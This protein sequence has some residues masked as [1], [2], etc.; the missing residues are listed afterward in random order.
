MR[1]RALWLRAGLGAGL[2]SGLGAG[3]ALG[4]VGCAAEDGPGGGL[5]D[6]GADR[7]VAFDQ[8]VDRG[9]ADQGAVACALTDRFGP[10]T[11]ELPAADLS[12]GIALDLAVCAAE[13]DWFALE[14]PVGQAVRVQVTADRRVRAALVDPAGAVLAQAEGRAPAL[15]GVAPLRGLR[16]RVEGL[17]VGTGYDLQVTAFE[18]VSGC[19]VDPQEAEDREGG[20]A[21]DGTVTRGLC[22][23]DRD[24]VRVPGEPGD[25]VALRVV[26][27]EGAAVQAVWRQA[28]WRQAGARSAIATHRGE[29]TPGRIWTA[30]RRLSDASTTLDVTG[31]PARYRVEAEVVSAQGGSAERLV[32]SRV[33]TPDRVST[34]EGTRPAAERP[35]PGLPVLLFDLSGLVVDA[36]R[37]DG[38]GDATWRPW[39]TPEE[40][41]EGWPRTALASLPGPVAVEVGPAEG[42]DGATGPW[43]VPLVAV[44]EVWLPEGP[45]APALHV[46]TTL[47]EGLDRLASLPAAAGVPRSLEVDAPFAVEA[48]AVDGGDWPG[49]PVVRARWSPAWRARCGACFVPARSP[50][51]VFSG[52]AADPDEWDEAVILHELGHWVAAVLGHDDSPG[53]A[54][55]GSPVAPTL[56]WSEGLADFFAAWVSGSPVLYDDR[57]DRVR[58][59]DLQ[60]DAHSEAED[61]APLTA[62]ISEHK[63][64]KLL[65]FLH[66]GALADRDEVL[67][68]PLFVGLPAVAAGAVADRGAPG[69]ELADW[70]A[71][72]ACAGEVDAAEAAAAA[73]GLGFEAPSN[74][75]CR[76]GPSAP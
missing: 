36:A 68:R 4:A 16:L 25:Q 54:H 44:G 67:W 37:G 29:A 14:V 9:P 56:A 12:P 50:Y 39:L 49:V 19:E 26:V 52:A 71:S 6:G 8:A 73:L 57:G 61:R 75:S 42:G 7:D 48:G 18:P 11:A 41:P 60:R 70:L 3:L 53:G 34:A 74:E 21:V 40:D 35:A 64:S 27:L 45:A 51:L 5:G 72:L 43:A 22:D 15:A 1:L 46:L 62:P 58:T 33:L 13:V 2:G 10:S 31:G 59:V 32:Q 69:V 38:A 63:V 23:G 20:A 55:D 30:T 28:E 66:Q 24:R 47:A 17:E 65:W 76:A